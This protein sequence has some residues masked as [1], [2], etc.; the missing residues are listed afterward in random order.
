MTN[1]L[2]FSLASCECERN[3]FDHRDKYSDSSYEPNI[4]WRIVLSRLPLG[5]AVVVYTPTAL[6]RSMRV[7][8]SRTR[9]P[10]RPNRQPL[11]RLDV[12]GNTTRSRR[13][14]TWMTTCTCKMGAAGCLSS[15][16]DV[17]RLM[18]SFCLLEG[19]LH[20]FAEPL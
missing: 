12:H 5:L 3:R 18:P 11:F 6:G 4:S 15:E 13:S 1:I 2:I 7:T 16:L 19:R 8:P 17:L 14:C 20:A 10:T 9:N